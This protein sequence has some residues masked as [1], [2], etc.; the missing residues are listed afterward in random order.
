MNGQKCE[1]TRVG[2]GS[3]IAFP[4]RSSDGVLDHISPSSLKLYLSCSLKYYFKKVLGLPEPVSPA[5]H[6]GKS[7]HAAI[8]AFW[9]AKWRGGDS[10]TET[11]SQA[12]L[13]A[14]NALLEADEVVYAEGEKEKSLAKGDAVVRAY[15]ESEHAQVDER[16][17]GVE[18]R[19]EEHLGPLPSP[20]LG[21]IDLVRPGNVVV[22][23][24]TCAS[25]PNAQLEAFQHELQLVAY[26]L[27]VEASTGE[28]VTARELVFLVKTKTPKV[29]VHRI[30]P[31]DSHAIERFWSVAEAAVEGIYHERWTPQPGMH[32]AWC[33]YRRE[34]SQWKGGAI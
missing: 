11:I 22:D 1:S 3:L 7:V 9:L 12:F 2:S 33:P 10:D 18:V 15:L 8:Q 4:G 25:T 6:L 13:T 20:L 31:A 28:R 34:C 16:P 24:K 27:L 29:I 26:Q 32:C 30:E 21:Y 14:F 19:L 23:F 5:L 17:V